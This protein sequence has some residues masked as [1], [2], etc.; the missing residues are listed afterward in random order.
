MTYVACERESI[1]QLWLTPRCDAHIQCLFLWRELDTKPVLSWGAPRRVLS[2]RLTAKPDWAPA[3]LTMKSKTPLLYIFWVPTHFTF[4][5]NSFPRSFAY[6]KTQLHILFTKS[7]L[8]GCQKSICNMCL[9][10]V[11][12][13]VIK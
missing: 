10:V 9:C 2:T 6:L 12:V 11:C 1:G 4:L 13:C 5:R 3:W 8:T 7:T